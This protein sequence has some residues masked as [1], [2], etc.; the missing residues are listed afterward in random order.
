LHEAL[1]ATLSA[2]AQRLTQDISSSSGSSSSSNLKLSSDSS[3]ECNLSDAAELANALLQACVDLF[4]LSRVRHHKVLSPAAAAACSLP[5]MELSV[6]ALEYIDSVLEQ[7]QQQQ[8]QQDRVTVLI[9]LARLGEAALIMVQFAIPE[10]L[11]CTGETLQPLTLAVTIIAV[12]AAH[13]GVLQAST[14]TTSTPSSSS[15]SSSGGGGG[16]SSGGGASSSGAGSSNC[17]SDTVTGVEGSRRGRSQGRQSNPM[18]PATGS[19]S[20]SMLSPQ[21]ALDLVLRR[22]QQ[23]PRFHPL[24]FEVL[25]VAQRLLAWLATLGELL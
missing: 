9:K 5:A 2:A 7:Q 1:P 17:S 16:S 25:G 22:E 14:N 19:S 15:S 10:L 11:R 20:S 6:A 18:S 13:K 8:Q 3:W 4:Q 23:L 12:V 21:E 24:L